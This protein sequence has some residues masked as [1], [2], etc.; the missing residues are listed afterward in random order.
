MECDADRQRL[1]AIDDEQFLR[2]IIDEANRSNSTFYPI[3]P[4]GLVALETGGASSLSLTADAQLR[5]THAQSMRELADGT[6]GIA[7]MDT[8]DLDK[9]LRKISDD[10]TSY[11]LLGYYSTNSKARWRVSIAEGSSEAAWRGRPRAARVPCRQR[12]GSDTRAKGRGGSGCGRRDADPGRHGIPR[13]DPTGLAG[14]ASRH[15]GAGR[16]SAVDRRRAL[17]RAGPRR[18]VG[19][20]RDR[21]SADLQRLGDGGRPRHDQGRRPDLPDVGQAAARQAG[22]PRRAGADRSDRQR[23][24]ARH[25]VHPPRRWRHSRSSTGVGRRPPIGRCQPPIFDSRAPI[26]PISSCPSAPEVKPGSGRLL[27]RTGQA[28]GVPVTMGERTDDASGQHWITADVALAPLAPGTTSIEMG[29]DR[30]VR[31]VARR[32]RYSRR[33]VSADEEV[34]PTALPGPR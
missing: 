11:Y 3:D 7:V 30:E 14:S 17:G 1:S 10:L 28:L 26:A 25:G 13:V 21:R 19:A 16:R 9:G 18:R 4:R 12:G 33:P 6:D 5:R 29:D 24:A 22:D 23:D 20:G 27:D 34:G 31:R 32:C 15:T 2:D 8:N